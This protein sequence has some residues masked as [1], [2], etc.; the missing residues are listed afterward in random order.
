[1]VK[2]S[3]LAAGWLLVATIFS[4][5][6]PV[7]ALAGQLGGGLLVLLGLAA[8]S[9]SGLALMVYGFVWTRRVRPSCAIGAVSIGAP[10]A[11]VLLAWLLLPVWSELSWQLIYGSRG[12]RIWPY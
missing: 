2:P 9:V 3:T 12:V 8:G 7:L 6:L 1:M 11:A 4:W 5:S 10:V